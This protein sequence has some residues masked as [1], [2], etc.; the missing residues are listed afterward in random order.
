MHLFQTMEMLSH[1]Q[2]QKYENKQNDETKRDTASR[3]TKTG[4]GV[5]AD[6]VDKA[7][8]ENVIAVDAKQTYISTYV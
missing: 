6:V 1:Y 3:T 8:K 4:I 7:F 2:K 5:E